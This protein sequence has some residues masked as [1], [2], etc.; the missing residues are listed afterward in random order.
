M[1]DMPSGTRLA[2]VSATLHLVTAAVRF[3]CASMQTYY[4]T[5]QFNPN[6]GIRG[7]A[8]RIICWPARTGVCTRLPSAA[9]VSPGRSANLPR[10]EKSK[11]VQPGIE[12]LR[13]QPRLEVPKTPDWRICGEQDE[14]PEE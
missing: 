9:R 13:H 11:K 12:A 8:D 3:E 2:P 5:R 7:W 10:I 6:F 14:V 4:R 1:P